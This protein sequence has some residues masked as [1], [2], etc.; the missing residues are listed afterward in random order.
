VACIADVLSGGLEFPNYEMVN[1]TVVDGTHVHMTLNKVHAVGAVIAVGGLCGYGLEQT[2]D[3]K[4]GIRQVFP[5]VGSSSATSLYYGDGNTPIVGN[6]GDP[7]TSAYMNWSATVATISRTSNVVTVTTAGNLP[8]DVNGLTVTVSG[9]ADTS[10]NGNYVVTTTGP[11]S[12]TYSN[13]GAN[14]T[15]SGGTLSYLTGGFVLYPM[16][17]VLSVFNTGTKNVDGAFTLAPN[18]VPWSTGDALEQPHY[19]QQVTDADNELVSQFVPR[20]VQYQSAGKD[21]AGEVGPG[22]R[23]WQVLNLVPTTE[24]IGGGGTHPTPYTAFLSS[25][26][27]NTNLEADAGVRAVIWA[28][29]NMHGCNRWDSGYSLFDLDSATGQDFLNFSPQSDSVSWQLLGT[30]YTFSPTAFTAGTINVGTL[31]ATTISGGVSGSSITSGTVSAARLPVF[32][33]SGSSHAAGIVPDPAATAGSTR[34]LRE[35]GTWNVPAGGAWSTT[36]PAPTCGSGTP[37]TISST[38]S[39]NQA[40]KTANLNIDVKDTSNGTCSGQITV[41]LPFTLATSSVLVCKELNITGYTGTALLVS[42]GTTANLLNYLGGT[43]AASGAEIVCS[44]TV[45]T[46]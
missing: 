18:T 6:Q 29:C 21:Y 8:A 40:G 17:E 3:T 34:Y 15:S 16:A 44:G 1:Y 39:A 11:N 38:V 4:N 28:H 2:I 31:N 35:D 32:G 24:Y 37:T 45:Q 12:L 9:I 33:P 30:S 43:Y 22:V 5:V 10:Y 13:T 36:T 26:V 20:P 42:G 14:S 23:G 25:G 19:Y 27:W 7:S 41:G 46:Q